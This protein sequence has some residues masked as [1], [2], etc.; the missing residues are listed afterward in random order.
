MKIGVI[1]LQG[2]FREHVGILKK[3]GVETVEV[4]MPS[5]LKDVKGLIIPGGEST[6]IGKLMVKYEL[7]K[8]IKEMTKK[9]MAVYGTCAGAILLAKEI[10]G[11]RQFCLGLIDIS[12][13]RNAYGRQIDSFEAE[14][15]IKGLGKFNA[16]FIRAPIIKEIRN[17][18]EILAKHGN[19]PVLLRKG[20][21]LVSTFHPELTDDARVHNYF[22][23]MIKDLKNLKSK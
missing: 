2:D 11:N 12:V 5:D 19:E 14:L 13:E 4:R 7:D 10:I 6:T 17:G 8:A 23:G 15:E 20:K 21:I 18:V 9:G 22:V 1:A 16:V 3:L